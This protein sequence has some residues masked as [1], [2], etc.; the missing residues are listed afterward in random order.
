M[1]EIALLILKI[2][3]SNLL[4]SLYLEGAGVFNPITPEMGV[5]FQILIKNLVSILISTAIK[6][7]RVVSVSGSQATLVSHLPGILIK[8]I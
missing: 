4:Q 8:F 1:S 7:A 3:L 6:T 2:D 5:G